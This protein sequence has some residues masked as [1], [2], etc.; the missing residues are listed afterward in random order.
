MDEQIL[1]DYFTDFYETP[2]PKVITRDITLDASK[3]PQIVIG[4]R[5]I[6][7][8]YL[9]FQK[10]NELIQNGV[11]KSQILYLNFEHIDLNNLTYKEI[12]LLLKLYWSIFPE[13]INQQLYLFF[14]EIQV[15]DKW[16]TALRTMMKHNFHIFVTG[17]SSK[18][19]NHEIATS[20]RGRAT[21]I[22]LYT[23]SFHEFLR[24]KDFLVLD[25]LTHLST[26]KQAKL[27]S[28]F[29][30]YF[31]YGGYPE[32]VLEEELHKKNTLLQNYYELIIYK[33]LIERYQL[34]NEHL[35]K[36]FIKTLIRNT[37]KEISVRKIFKDFKTRGISA[38]VD[39]LYRYLSILE[40][41]G[42]I[43]TIRRY[44]LSFRREMNSKPKIYVHDHSLL[45]LFTKY[46]YSYKFENLIFMH[47]KRRS[48]FEPLNQIYFWKTPTGKEI[49]FMVLNRD[50]ITELIQATYEMKESSTRHREINSL[51]SGMIDIERIF[52]SK[53]ECGKIIHFEKEN[54]VLEQDAKKIEVIN[55]IKYL[56]EPLS[57]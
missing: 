33:D 15:I 47:L 46:N 29:E 57:D 38:T 13:E 17:S 25:G 42:I 43:Y 32:V 19:L 27:Q 9:M 24:F 21:P 10:M 53:I 18:L 35:I 44:D 11:R 3:R 41:A 1:R 20:F 14:D 48:Y 4:A 37:A 52:K 54:T 45:S 23:L 31:E 6:G 16:E 2:L 30:E 56:L 22:F 26:K 55:I 28:L 8:T 40:D 5:R 34:R 50:E 12:P 36:E 49:D 51:V 7:K 39:T